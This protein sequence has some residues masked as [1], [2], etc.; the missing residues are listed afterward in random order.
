MFMDEPSLSTI[1]KKKKL[2]ERPWIK[3]G[4]NVDRGQLI[5]ITLNGLRR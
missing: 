2:V 3:I 4:G 5:G 1:I